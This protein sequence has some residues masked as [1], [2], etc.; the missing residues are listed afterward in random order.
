MDDLEV[1]RLVAMDNI[2]TRRITRER[3]GTKQKN[4]RREECAGRVTETK[5]NK[6]RNRTAAKVRRLW[7]RRITI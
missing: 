4:L 2:R 5:E 7:Y 1:I 3:G 6:A